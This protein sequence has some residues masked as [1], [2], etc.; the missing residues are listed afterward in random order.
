MA[1]GYGGQ[2]FMTHEL[3]R[4]DA[5]D[6]DWELVGRVA[7]GDREAFSELVERHHR[8]LLRVCER[9]L[10]DPEDARDAVQ[11]VFLKVLRKA[12]GFRPHAL[13]STLLYRIA[14]NHCLNQL[15]RRR[16]I[17]M[18]SLSPAP[19]DDDEAPFEPAEERPDAERELAA[20]QRWRTTRRAIA[21]LPPGQRA[22]LVLARFEGLAY[23]EIAETLGITLGAVESRLVR[24]MRALE[25]V[26][27]E[28]DRAKVAQ[29]I[30]R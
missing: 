21:A 30:G 13:V 24:A 7:R 16:L 29:E 5:V 3:L 4:D 6:P 20:R 23:K 18:I 14:V 10:G 12:G 1:E 28:T 27:A 19:P 26:P 15:R 11:E 9:L 17:R 8:R 2:A 25:R 22:V